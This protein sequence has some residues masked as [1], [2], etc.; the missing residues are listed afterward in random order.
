MTSVHD[1]IF[2]VNNFY[3]FILWDTFGDWKFDTE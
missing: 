1:Y 2:E 3:D